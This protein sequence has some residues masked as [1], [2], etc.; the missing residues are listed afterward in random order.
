L[1]FRGFRD[2]AKITYQLAWQLP[3]RKFFRWRYHLFNTSITNPQHGVRPITSI[4][5]GFCVGL[6]VIIKA[7][8]DHWEIDLS[9]NLFRMLRQTNLE[10]QRTCQY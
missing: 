7:G 9:I 4:A 3:A 8:G 1:D 2:R 10:L 6:A 5:N